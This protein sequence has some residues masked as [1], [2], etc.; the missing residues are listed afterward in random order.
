MKTPVK[1]GKKQESNLDK[2]RWTKGQ[3]GNPKGRPKKEVCITELIR[4]FGKTFYNEEERITYYK[5]MTKK[6]WEKAAEGDMAAINFIAERT[7]GK[8]KQQID[9]EH[10]GNSTLEV[11][12]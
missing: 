9:I 3:S 8:A 7:E 11:I 6:L 12:N 1:Q 5:Q 4:T 10:T 2:G